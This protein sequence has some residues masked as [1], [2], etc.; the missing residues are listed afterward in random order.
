MTDALHCYL[1]IESTM[2][3]LDD[4][5]PD[6]SAALLAILDA[7]WHTLSDDDRARLLDRGKRCVRH[8]ACSDS[9]CAGCLWDGNIWEGDG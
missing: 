7:R 6:V 1:L 4:S 5:N 8:R 9:G 3:L 2:M